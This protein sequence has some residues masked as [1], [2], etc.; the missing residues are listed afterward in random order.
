MASQ[1]GEGAAAAKS[2]LQLPL[3]SCMQK[4]VIY[5]TKAVSL[6]AVGRGVELEGPDLVMIS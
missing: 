1:S 3:I 5:E 2:V 4:I 6:S